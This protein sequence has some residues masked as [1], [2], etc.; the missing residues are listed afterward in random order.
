MPLYVVAAVT[1][2]ALFER[3]VPVAELA[4]YVGL[5]V[6]WALPFR[7]VFRGVA[8][9]DPDTGKGETPGEKT[10]AEDDARRGG[11]RRQRAEAADR[12]NVERNLCPVPD[13]R[14]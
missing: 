7:F 2:L 13:A 14:S 5:G 8:R 1:I 4:I 10:D 9:P 3:P 6:L 12:I 11:R